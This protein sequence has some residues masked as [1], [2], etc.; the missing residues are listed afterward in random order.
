MSVGVGR[1]W[2]C[3]LCTCVIEEGWDGEGTGSEV[4]SL[5]SYTLRYV[6]WC[7][8]LLIDK[9][10]SKDK[11]YF[12][13]SVWWK[14]HKCVYVFITNWVCS[15]WIEKDWQCLLWIKKART[16][17]K[18]YIWVSVWWKTKLLKMRNLYVSHTMSCTGGTGT[19]KDKDE[20][21]KRDVCECDGPMNL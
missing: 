13:M 3:I 5:L 6:I 12:W 15:L 18:T 20:V 21:D 10:R 2:D 8:L 4:S 1:V 17:D 19:P 14:T 11:T 9:T 7:C 16:K